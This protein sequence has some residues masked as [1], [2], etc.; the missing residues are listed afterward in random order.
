ME[1]TDA[2]VFEI[3]DASQISD[4]RRNIATFAQLNGFDEKNINR[5]SVTSTEFGTNL[6]K[7]TEMGGKLIVQSLTNGDSV[8]VEIFSI[9]SGRGMDAEKCIEDGVSSSGTYGT[10]LGAIKRMSDESNFYSKL[11]SGTVIQTRTWTKPVAK[12]DFEF[13]A[14]TVPKRGEQISGDKWSIEKNENHLLC[15]VIDG[16]GHGVE[17]CDASRL[18]KKRFSENLNKPPLEILKAIHTSLRGTRGAV[19]LVARIDLAHN[20]VEYSG[21]GN[22]AGV[23]TTG[24]ERKHMVSMNGTL[25]YEARKMVQYSIP[26]NLNSTLVMHSDGLSSKTFHALDDISEEPAEIIAGWLYLL[27]AKNVDDETVLVVKQSRSK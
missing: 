15:M 14:F 22:I 12:A 21:L 3:T 2:L 11:E 20:V 18:A 7:H 27:N 8:C 25:G 26:W 19:G 23:I 1:V 24:G 6:L 13:G 5:L 4:A 10:G 16:L 17:A 9:D